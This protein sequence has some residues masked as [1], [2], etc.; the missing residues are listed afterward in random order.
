MARKS[1]LGLMG[2]EDLVCDV[3]TVS[4]KK[5]FECD[6]VTSQFNPMVFHFWHEGALVSVPYTQIAKIVHYQVEK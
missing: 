3:E 2:V 5:Y 1:H 6:T 4:G